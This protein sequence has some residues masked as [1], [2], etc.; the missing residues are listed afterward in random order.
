M[1]FLGARQVWSLEL[2]DIEAIT[3]QTAATG[4]GAILEIQTAQGTLRVDGV[5]P[6]AARRITEL[7][8]QLRG[9]CTVSRS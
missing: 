1:G 5:G 2:A 7:V 4:Q 8:L 9:K 6:T 3:L